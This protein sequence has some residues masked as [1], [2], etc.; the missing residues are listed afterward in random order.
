MTLSVSTLANTLLFTPVY[1]HLSTS[2][3]VP[4]CRPINKS[5]IETIRELHTL[6]VVGHTAAPYK[7]RT[8][9]FTFG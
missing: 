4:Y 6:T 8:T 1:S 3:S 7:T 2:T 5:G 9:I